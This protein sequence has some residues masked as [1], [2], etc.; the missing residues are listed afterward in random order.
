MTTTIE[1]DRPQQSTRSVTEAE[2]S[3]KT[4]QPSTYYR[5]TSDEKAVFQTSYETQLPLM[6]AGPTGCGK[7]RLVEHMA[8]QLGRPLI[9][10]A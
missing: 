5:E 3:A 6:L 4:A 10:V 7:T 9:T 8:E 2:N 1:L